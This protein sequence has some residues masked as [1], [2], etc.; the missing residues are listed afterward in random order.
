[1]NLWAAMFALAVSSI[2]ILVG[3]A[4]TCAVS[5]GEVSEN[6]RLKLVTRTVN[7]E[8]ES[9][10]ADGWTGSVVAVAHDTVVFSLQ[11]ADFYPMAEIHFVYE[12]DGEK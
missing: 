3:P 5:C 9:T 7:G 10:G 12:R 6:Y 4:E 11:D 1:M 2:L 8:D